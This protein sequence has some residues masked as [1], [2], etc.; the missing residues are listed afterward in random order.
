VFGGRR[1]WRHLNGEVIYRSHPRSVQVRLEHHR[2]CEF[3]LE[4]T[5]ACDDMEGD[6]IREAWNP[7]RREPGV[8]QIHRVAAQTSLRAW[9]GPE[10]LHRRLLSTT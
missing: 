6:S 7:Q 1:D 9:L 3:V 2:F 10:D 8:I 4:T 5:N